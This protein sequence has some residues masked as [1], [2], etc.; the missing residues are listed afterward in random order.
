VHERVPHHRWACEILERLGPTQLNCSWVPGLNS[1]GRGGCAKVCFEADRWIKKLVLLTVTLACLAALSCALTL[2]QWFVASRFPLHERIA[3]S[4]F[5]PAISI[6]KPL[7]GRDLLTERC[8]RSW[9]EQHYQGQ[10][11][12]LFGVASADDPVCSLVRKL[13]ADFPDANAE[14]VVCPQALGANA[15]VSTLVHLQARARHDLLVISDADVAVPPEL[16]R[17][18]VAPFQET[19][20]GVVHCFYKLAN[21]DTAAMRWE[22]VAINAD[23]WS[24]VL[25]ARSL[26][27][28]DFAL[29]AV[30]ATTRDKLESI[31][32]FSAL[33]DCLADD[34]QLGNRIARRGGR[35]VLC[36]LVVE[37]WAPPMGWRD[38]WTHQ[39]RWAR[40]IRVCKPVPFFFSI[41]SNATFWPSLWIIADP[42]VLSAVA[43]LVTGAVRIA[44]AR[45]NYRRLT[46]ATMPLADLWLVPLKDWLGL[47]TW[48]FAFAGNR[49]EWRGQQFHMRR[50]GTLLL[51]P[52][53]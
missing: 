45:S 31:G 3:D 9:F 50:D 46:R 52:E 18:L 38:V 53:P 7:K 13:M 22:A 19:D 10:S 27:P 21:P 6:L 29:G 1:T 24:Q 34:Y 2:W 12:L 28:L 47:A 30:M 17:N 4:A 35:I 8:L 14:L 16:V 51:W 25:Q 37:C 39:L 23:F 40:T 20:V 48:A 43:L 42:T 15:K 32:G 11:Q 44:T 26:K 33:L 36:P 49:V 5:A 41:L